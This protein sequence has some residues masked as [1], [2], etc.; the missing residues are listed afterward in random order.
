MY[1]YFVVSNPRGWKVFD[2]I[3]RL[4]IPL[5]TEH[6]DWRDYVLPTRKAAQAIADRLNS[7]QKI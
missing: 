7:A 4:S 5:S 3:V 6:G 2:T 1:R